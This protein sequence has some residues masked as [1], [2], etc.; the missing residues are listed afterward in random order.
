M[1]E[2]FPT[3]SEFRNTDSYK[4]AD[5]ATKLRADVGYVRALRNFVV[6][7]GGQVTASDIIKD[8]ADKGLFARP[9]AAVASEF[10]DIPDDARRREQQV[11]EGALAAIKE[12]V[13]TGVRLPLELMGET[14]RLVGQGL[15]TAKEVALSFG[16]LGGPSTRMSADFGNL[17]A[18]RSSSALQ[19]QREAEAQRGIAVESRELLGLAVDGSE[20]D[21]FSGQLP[22]LQPDSKL[23]P[24]R[25]VPDTTTIEQFAR[26]IEEGAKIIRA[27]RKLDDRDRDIAK[28]PITHPARVIKA[29]EDSSTFI[30]VVAL[31]D[32]VGGPPLAL[33]TAK[34]M[35]TAS[36][37]PELQEKDIPDP[38]KR[39][40]IQGFARA[41]LAAVFPKF[42]TALGK[43]GVAGSTVDKIGRG[44]TLEGLT[45]SA[46]ATIDT[47]LSG[48]TLEFKDI[49]NELAKPENQARILEEGILA[50]LSGGLITAPIA[51]LE[52]AIEKGVNEGQ[53]DEQQVANVIAQ[54]KK[55]GYAEEDVQ[56]LIETG[57]A[58]LAAPEKNRQVEL[59]DVEDVQAPE[60]ARQE[61]P[62]QA[63]PQPEPEPTVQP[64]APQPEPDPTEVPD[65]QETPIDTT[66]ETTTPAT[67][68]EATT[69][70]GTPVEAGLLTSPEQ[71][72]FE[73]RIEQEDPIQLL[74]QQVAAPI[75]RPD[76][77]SPS[78]IPEQQVSIDVVDELRNELG[79]PG[80]RSQADVLAEAQ[81]RI[82]DNPQEQLNR[83]LTEGPRTAGTK[84][85]V[86]ILTTRLLMAGEGL[87]AFESGDPQAIKD[88]M[89]LQHLDRQQGTETARELA[90]RRSSALPPADRL[91]EFISRALYD[92]NTPTR[93]KL[94]KLA[95]EGKDSEIDKILTQETA[96][97]EGIRKALEDAGIDI[98]GLGKLDLNNDADLLKMAEAS[99]IVSTT[100]AT[101]GDKWYEAWRNSIL[102]AFTTQG[103]NIIGNT[104]N[105]AWDFTVQRM[106]EAT[107]NEASRLI[108]KDPADDLAP[109]LGELQ[110][111]WLG[112]IGNTINGLKVANLT[113]KT[114]LPAFDIR[115][116]TNTPLEF[117]GK[118]IAGRKGQIIRWPFRALL[119][120]DQ[121]AR[122][123][124]WNGQVN[125]IA[126]RMAKA[127]GLSGQALQNRM[128]EILA[129]PFSDAS[130]FALEQTSASDLAIDKATELTFQT[131]LG[132]VG[133]RFLRLR[134]APG[135]MGVPMK[136]VFP[137]VVTPANIFKTGIRKSPLGSLKLMSD[138]IT[139]K[140]DT[141]L[142][143]SAEQ[144]LA[145]GST[146]LVWSML[147]KEDEE[148]GLPLITGSQP[149]ISPRQASFERRQFQPQS[150]LIN[151]RYV[152]YSRIEPFA[153]VLATTVDGLNFFREKETR[154]T[155][156]AFD[157]TWK[158]LIGQFRDKTFLRGLGDFIRAVEEPDRGSRLAQNFITSW[159]PNLVRSALRSRDEMVRDLRIR[160]KEDV[161]FFQAL[162]QRV[163]QGWVP[164]P[165]LA[166]PPRHDWLGRPIQKD[167]MFDTPGADWLY[168]MT[169]PIRTQN[170]AEITNFDRLIL[171]YNNSNPN[172]EFYPPAMS[173]KFKAGDQEFK[174]DDAQYQE[175]IRLSGEKT[176]EKLS[177][178][179]LNYE[180][181]TKADVDRIKKAVDKSRDE[182]K[183]EMFPEA[184]FKRFRIIPILPPR[185][186]GARRRP[187]RRR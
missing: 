10:A 44:M 34:E 106:T 187:T 156:K 174:L 182:A 124:I 7:N 43:G 89:K 141:R 177:D 55:L 49:R 144:V 147:N 9:E 24:R 110:H 145:V 87:K 132:E 178:M 17:I 165:S 58:Q 33:L 77:A 80:T 162:G 5:E 104:T 140:K 100:K 131:Q 152:S 42:L 153:T 101:L 109:R 85:D 163:V 88:F 63:E 1:A 180:D 115:I 52:I 159:M 23:D 107:L 40:N 175:L 121:M 39:A 59:E 73:Q 123:M 142:R 186:R 78:P 27:R 92:V 79:L 160:N 11:R 22:P 66:A 139:G 176:L 134:D 32:M 164:D 13:D 53:L 36:S 126:F 102:S 117:Q 12:T 31:A 83:L 25:V 81:K 136:V 41:P 20:D 71:Q 56:R 95:G 97:A 148:T 30:A 62:T 170:T 169:V 70:D 130:Q 150:I 38:L 90:I 135:L 185:A 65:A 91:K 50:F 157:R 112:A 35:I 122:M 28:L 172:E 105:S 143:D 84:R 93:D 18:T 64:T 113:W 173:D 181:P 111:A 98:E 118:A 26:N 15:S 133:Q 14:K 60:Q 138:L 21:Q 4:S 45:E 119:A 167:D 168:R 120:A 76:L 48:T 94:R 3:L 128:T 149:F 2:Q 46:E 116:G 129:D 69:E 74:Q 155:S 29:V 161:E 137:F 75:P 51:M 82:Q 184:R 86:D 72:A 183:R 6:D 171:N 61:S 127:E 68:T 146:M 154:G 103:A 179:T 108:G 114:E 37:L 166:P 47:A 99:R 16:G 151:G 158:K 8:F 54:A 67:P 96:R 57:N 19:K 125:A